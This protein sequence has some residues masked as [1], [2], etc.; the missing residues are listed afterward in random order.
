MTNH[1]YQGDLPDGLDLGPLVAVDT[2]TQGLHLQRDRLCVV[3]LCGGD[4]QC[5]IVHFPTADFAAPNLK[6]LLGNP[7]VTKILQYARFDV[8]V[9]KRHLG[10]A[11]SP[12]YCT[13]IASKLVRTYTDKHGL[14]ALCRELLNIDLS[15]QQ[16]SSDWAAA[17]LT[18]AQLEYAAN[19][20]LYLHKLK[21]KLDIMLMRE[22]RA[23][24]AQACFDFLPT[25]AD[26]DLNGWGDTDI[27]SHA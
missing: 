16:Q 24:L 15:K 10:V 9:I 13:K 22:D 14:S 21:E 26:L 17:E 19:D 2:E 27:F 5:H 3:Q 4:D 25:R 20:V 1:Y 18:Q 12:L 7:D 23:A 11:M 6:R 8:A